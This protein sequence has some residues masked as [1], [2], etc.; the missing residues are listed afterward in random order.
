M[1]KENNPQKTNNEENN[2]EKQLIVKKKKR[3]LTRGRWLVSGI[4]TILL[5]AIIISVYILVNILLENVTLPEF[6]LTE[7]KVYSLSEE[8]KTKLKNLGNEVK[9]TLINYQ[10]N[11][12]VT[13]FAEKYKGLNNNIKVE[14]INDITS[15]KDLMEEYSLDAESQLIIINSGENEK[16]L[17]EYDLYTYDYS[18][19]ETIDTTEEAFTNAIVEVITENKPKVYFMS[20][21]IQYDVDKYFPTI[22]KLMKEDANEVDKID[23][24]SFGSVPEDCNTLI[25]TTLAEDITEFEKDKIIEYINRGGELLILSGPNMTGKNLSNFHEILNQYGVSME[26]GIVFEGNSSNMLYGYPDFIVEKM[27]SSSLTKK[28]NMNLSICLADSAS[29][30]FDSDKKEELNV[31]FEE[32]VSTSNKAFRRTDLTVN[33]PSRVDSDSEQGKLVV[34]AIANKTIDENNNSKLIIFGNELFASS[35]SV[36]LNGYNYYIS[37]LYNN[38][39]IVLNSI[40]YLNEREDTITIRKSYDT[41]TYTATQLQHNIIMIIIFTIPVIII[42]VGII[43][44][45]VRRRKK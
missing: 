36:T 22:I 15:R 11:D 24:L 17:R 34:G 20:N 39:D 37:E 31:E 26:E 13:N 9:I 1:K 2:N 42:I 4:A 5:V 23:I 7:N 14:K 33:T 27:Q 32:L 10:E 21:H 40:A 30:K 8:T 12:S 28:V 41:V 6:D 16:T 35:M 44:W 25:I 19:Y 38:T 18:T 29:I 3:E 45:Q 43:V